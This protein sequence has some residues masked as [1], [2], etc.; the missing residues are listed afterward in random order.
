MVSIFKGLCCEKTAELGG[1]IRIVSLIRMQSSIVNTPE[2]RM[3]R[4]RR[5]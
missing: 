3:I 1:F 4:N 5:G 2:H